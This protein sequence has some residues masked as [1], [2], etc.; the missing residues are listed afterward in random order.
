MSNSLLACAEI[1]I[2]YQNCDTSGAVDFLVSHET[3]L[4]DSKPLAAIS[5][6]F[7]N[8]MLLAT[9]GCQS[10][11]QTSMR[12]QNRYGSEWLL[13]VCGESPVPGG[14]RQQRASPHLTP[15]IGDT[16]FPTAMLAGPLA[17]DMLFFTSLSTAYKFCID[18]L[19]NQD[20]KGGTVCALTIIV[21]QCVV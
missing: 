5:S 2:L 11:D 15:S 3:E 1:L 17:M 16:L 13:E 7:Q 12:T 10:D 20:S 18:N 9:T 19:E 8:I 14:F 4:A 6:A 21:G